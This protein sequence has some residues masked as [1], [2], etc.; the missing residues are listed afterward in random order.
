MKQ[1]SKDNLFASVEWKGK[2]LFVYGYMSAE[3]LKKIA[4]DF[5]DGI[6]V[7][8]EQVEVKKNPPS[9]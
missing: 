3:E 4:K 9:R 7:K 5:R 8:H 6:E 2:T 1:M